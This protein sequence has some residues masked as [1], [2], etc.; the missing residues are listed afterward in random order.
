[1]KMIDYLPDHTLTIQRTGYPAGTPELPICD[2][3]HQE[4]GWEEEVYSLDGEWVCSDCFE[5]D[6]GELGL[7]L[8]AQAM[9]IETKKAYEMHEIYVMDRMEE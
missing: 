5:E 9:D 6:L 8:I 3:C 7:S 2:R 4:I 1:M